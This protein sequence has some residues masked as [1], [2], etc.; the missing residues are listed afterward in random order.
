MLSAVESK[1]VRL[2]P[3]DQNKGA[4][5]MTRALTLLFAIAAGA[6]VG[7]LYSAQPLLADIATTMQVSV[8]AVSILITL[9]QMGYALGVFLIVP[10]G[11]TLSRR[12]LIPAIMTCSAI[13]LG[14]CAVAPTFPAL[15]V[16]FAAVG[17]TTVAGQLLTP[18]AGDLA[19]PSQRGRV[20]GTI[21]SGILSGI[22]LSAQ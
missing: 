2:A 22:L 10:L 8:V 9:T 3:S 14:A 13:A 4:L 6:A 20:V 21:V 19:E 17:L 15:L 18:F 12:R 11:D 5:G 16:A 1:R 7:N